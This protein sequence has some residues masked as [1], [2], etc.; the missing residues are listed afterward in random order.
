MAS[1]E[2]AWPE[3][4]SFATVLSVIALSRLDGAGN[5]TSTF[6]DR[7]DGVVNCNSVDIDTATFN[8]VL[9]VSVLLGRD[10]GAA[11][12][13]ESILAI[14]EGGSV[15]LDKISYSTVMSVLFHL[16]T[17]TAPSTANDL[18]YCLITHCRPDTVAYNYCMSIYSNT[19]TLTAV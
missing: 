1:I 19:N 17:P 12:K 4:F 8:A 3:K 10:K 5:R 14:M 16:T 7:L 6:L 9:K 2:H 11:K 13:V 15:C 18:Y